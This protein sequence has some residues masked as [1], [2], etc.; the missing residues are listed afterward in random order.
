MWENVIAS[1][2]QKISEYYIVDVLLKKTYKFGKKKHVRTY[3]SYGPNRLRTKRRIE[4][5]SDN[6]MIIKYF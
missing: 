6:L 4:V 3:G 1:D 2:E 5:Q